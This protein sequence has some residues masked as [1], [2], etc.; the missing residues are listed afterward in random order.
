MGRYFNPST[1][2]AIKENGGRELETDKGTTYLFEEDY[3][4]FI[5]QLED[6]EV[7]LGL[8]MRPAQG[9]NNAVWLY[10]FDEMLQFEEQERDGMILRIGFYAFPK[11]NFDDT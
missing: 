5:A 7:L 3:E 9:F 11:S 4:K 6:G 10:K 8:Y 2:E 1:A